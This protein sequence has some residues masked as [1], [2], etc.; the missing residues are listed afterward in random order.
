MTLRQRIAA[1]VPVLLPLSAVLTACGGSGGSDGTP[2]SNSA[3]A[4]A[5]TK[6]KA[7]YPYGDP[8]CMALS[9]DRK[10]AFVG[11][12]A[13]LAL[14]S[15]GS[16]PSPV[17]LKTQLA[18]D[19][20]CFSLA[21]AANRVF[22]CGGKLGL[23]E[24]S[25]C[26]GLTDSC[27]AQCS[28]YPV[29]AID[30]VDEKL[31][32]AAVPV[33]GHAA[34]GLVLALYSAKNASE[35]RV[36]DLAAPHALRAIVPVQGGAS[37]Q[38]FA[39]A[40]DPSD[41]NR[42]YAALGSGGIARIDIGDLAHVVV[43]PGPVFDHPDEL[44]F[45]QPARALDLSIA[46]GFLYA[47]IEKGGLAAIDLSA[48][49]S[50]SMSVLR[51]PLACGPNSVAFGYRVAALADETGRVLVAV[52]THGG[53]SQEIDGGP[54]SLLGSWDFE[55]GLGNAPEP[56]PSDPVGCSPALFFFEYA[57]S[58]AGSGTCAAGT[59]CAISTVTDVPN[60][61]RSLALRRDGSTFQCCE[62][63]RDSFRLVDLGPNPFTASQFTYTL[64]GFQTSTGLAPIGGV[65]SDV[66]SGLLYLSNDPAGSHFAGMADITGG[67]G[68]LGIV[69]NTSDLCTQPGGSPMY[70]DTQDPAMDAPVPFKNGIFSTAHWV[71]P[72][73]S[74]R[75][76]FIGGET[77]MYEQCAPPCSYSDHWCDSIWRSPQSFDKPQPGW[78]I[79]SFLPGAGDG[80]LWQMRW[81]QLPSPPDT[82]LNP[83]RNY[84][85]SLADPRPDSPLLHL[86]RS[87]IGTGYL[88]CDRNELM[89][90][91]AN[92][93]E[94]ANGR[95][96][97]LDVHFLHVLPTHPELAQLGGS[98]AP[99]DAAAMTT[100]C[101]V[102]SVVAS[103]DTRW[104]AALSCGFPVNACAGAWQPYYQRAMV[105]F[106][107]VTTV[108]ADTPPPMLRMAFGP[109]G[110]QGNAFSLRT[111]EIDG[112]TYAFVADIGGRLLVFDVSGDVLFP[113]P[114]NP[115]SPATGL[116]PVGMWTSPPNAFDGYLDN[117][118]DVAIDLPYAYLATGRRGVT[119][120]DIASDPHAPHEIESSPVLTPGQALGL[121]V[122]NAAQ[123]P[124]LV[125]ADSRAGLRVYGRP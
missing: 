125:V 72:T 82:Q 95:G 76:W 49:W 75:E 86:T 1:L 93:C 18:V 24:L 97:K 36:Y 99:S 92:T 27:A 80:A 47:A 65:A 20:A 69:P 98:C 10:L 50:S 28:E 117:V 79:L 25:T 78:K 54:Y 108:H 90:T 43:E 45:G 29:S 14:L 63:R 116:A 114:S 110:I 68:A 39:L 70:C 42:A 123:D 94:Q 4:S 11:E 33:E 107:D 124:T 106:Y 118:I 102:F 111:A 119:V 66:N 122:R 61:W 57:T 31:C 91:A 38:A 26:P 40:A 23:F 60:P 64:L 12:G 59:L 62:C 32:I 120:L 89:A 22:L 56:Q 101:H 13:S 121:F 83:G 112:R 21:S 52:G 48:S 88:L 85:G 58:S 105:V 115:S 6:P 3:T 46:G 15:L 8:L 67:D 100:A 7:S 44:L 109:A 2:P 35:V 53:P 16:G 5:L 55:L 77:S 73:D 17:C 103:G 9:P 74:A 71:D 51:Q 113:A 34:G 81:W 37:S 41:P 96:Q 104:I 30:R 84:I 19:V 87:G